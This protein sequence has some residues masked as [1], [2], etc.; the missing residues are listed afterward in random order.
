MLACSMSPA[1]VRWSLPRVRTPAAILEKAAVGLGADAGIENDD[2]AAVLLRANQAAEALPQFYHRF[3]QLVIP[4]RDCRRL[5]G[6]LERAS[7]SG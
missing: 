3:G 1:S 7:S 2:D 4:E 6:S 5:R